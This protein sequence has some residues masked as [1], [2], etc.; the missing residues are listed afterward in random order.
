M[1]A[2]RLSGHRAL[3]AVVGFYLLVRILDAVVIVWSAG[4]GQGGETPWER[5]QHVTTSWDGDWY[6]SIAR[7]GY[8]DSAVGA[9]GKPVQTSLAFYPLFPLV[10]RALTTITGLPF[11]VVGPGLSLVAGVVATGL[12]FVLIRQ[13]VGVTRA[14]LACAVLTTFPAAP[15][16][17]LAYT[18]SLALALVATALLLI[19]RQSYVW[20]IVPVL[21]LGLTRNISLVV[22]AVVVARW[23]VAWR[24][25]R[26]HQGAPPPHAKLISLLTAT[27]LA[28][29]LWPCIVG[30]MTG[31]LTAYAT[32]MKAW[33]GYSPSVLRPPWLEA[34]ASTG[35]ASVLLMVIVALC[36][37][38]FMALPVTRAW[39]VELWS[40]AA[41][42]PV[43][44]F[45]ATGFVTSILRYLLLAFPLAL[46]VVPP[47]Q[48]S[49]D[50]VVRTVMVVAWGLIGL[51][52]QYFWIS[53]LLVPDAPGRPWGFP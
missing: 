46:A 45:L 38:G 26:R 36:F 28:A 10:A 6:S 12:L 5:Y 8:P 2:A 14:A 24:A 9:D 30:L 3:S 51:A 49:R 34:A 37:A 13:S 41:A 33:P 48:T 11:S 32:T 43:Y 7:D 4:P 16:L 21:A 53:P 23:A 39:G 20:A 47:V 31:D 50:R 27:I 25:H 22:G 44:I 15:V 29:L 18:E 17:Q 35:M 40:W 19:R 42:Y 52:G 1:P